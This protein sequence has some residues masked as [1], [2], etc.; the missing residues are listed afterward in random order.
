MRRG[1]RSAADAK[2]QTEAQRREWN[3]L[4]QFLLNSLMKAEQMKQISPFPKPGR[5]NK[6]SEAFDK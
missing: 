4:W 1:L 2:M 6:S 3:K 5:E